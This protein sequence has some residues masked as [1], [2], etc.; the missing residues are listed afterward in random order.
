MKLQGMG[1][2]TLTHDRC[3]YQGVN[4]CQWCKACGQKSNDFNHFDI[5]P[6]FFN[7]EYDFKSELLSANCHKAFEY[8]YFQTVQSE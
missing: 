3:W 1:V 7:N 6:P 4:Q 8:S 2:E 5:H